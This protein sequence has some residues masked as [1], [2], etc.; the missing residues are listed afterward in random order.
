MNDSNTTTKSV[1]SPQHR[2]RVA[3]LTGRPMKQGRKR[4]EIKVQGDNLLFRGTDF[5]KHSDEWKAWKTP[6]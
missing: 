1:G 3:F 6:F 2:R 4:I 5:E